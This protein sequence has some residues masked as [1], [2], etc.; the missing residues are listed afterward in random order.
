[1]P[2]PS[3]TFVIVGGGM[4]GGKAAETLRAEGFDGRVVIVAAE[5]VAPYERPPLSKGYLAGASPREEALLQP[6]A[7]WAEHGIELR[8]GR[9][10]TALDPASRRVELDDGAE[11]RYDRLLLATGAVPRRPPIA[12]AGLDGVLTLRTLADSDALRERLARPGARLAIVGGGWIG[13]EAAAAARALGAEVTLLEAAA[14]PLA[15]VLGA[16]LGA[17]FADLHRDHGVDVRTGVAVDEIGGRGRVE[18]VRLAD[19]ERIACDTVLLAVGV[20]PDT[21]LAEAAGLAVDDGIVVDERLAASAPDVLA[22][23]DAARAFHP[24]YRRHVRVE[25]WSTAL[26]QGIAAGRLLL[27]AGEPYARLPSFFSDQYDLGLEYVGLHAPGDRLVVRG[28]AAA[29]RLVAVWL[30]GGRRPTAAMH[31]NEWDAIEPLRRLVETAAPVDPERVADASVP[32]EELAG[33]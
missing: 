18:H 30:D 5:P 13:C 20:A 6:E 14:Q 29:R 15:G 8:T 1:M 16:S 19:G 3:R 22:A 10:A 24:R 7:W 28:D 26:N 31:V 17:V 11:L 25:H 27:G 2:E 12:G 4:A 32:L 33:A 21:A 9:R 23:G